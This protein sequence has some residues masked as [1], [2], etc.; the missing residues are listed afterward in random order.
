MAADWYYTTN[1]QQMGPVSWDELR[2]LASSGLLKPADMVWSD[3]M[4]E[5]V[6]A[7]RQDG[8]FTG[9]E[10]VTA[11][12]EREPP[13]R[14]RSRRREDDDEDDDRRPRDKPKKEG[15]AVGLKVGLIL[16]G[17]LLLVLVLLCGGGTAIYFAV[18]DPGGRPAVAGGQNISY[19]VNLNPGGASE[20]PVSVRQGQRVSVIVTSTVTMPNTDVDL[21]VQRGPNRIAGDFTIGPNCRVEFVAPATDRYGV[22]VNNRGPGAANSR[23][24]VIVQ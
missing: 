19:T 13:P 1:K 11:K 24:N 17:V 22:R 20:R 18:R 8:L 7:S 23:V 5:W 21:A 14:R 2:E 15:T 16:G 10:A 4:P 3:G 6:K 9:G 12:A